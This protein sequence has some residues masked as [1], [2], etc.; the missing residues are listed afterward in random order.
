MDEIFEIIDE[1]SEL[2]NNNLTDADMV[3]YDLMNIAII[4]EEVD[5][6]IRKIGIDEAIKAVIER[7]TNPYYGIERTITLIVR[8]M[9]EQGSDPKAIEGCIESLYDQGNVPIEFRK[10]YEHYTLDV[11]TR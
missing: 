10:T 1:E 6:W 4:S 3:K 11:L 7:N 8:L 9:T 5:E 2:K